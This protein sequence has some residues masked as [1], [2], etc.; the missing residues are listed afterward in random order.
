MYELTA[1]IDDAR[2]A[3]P[4][5][6]RL[7]IT[8]ALHGRSKDGMHT[9]KRNAQDEPFLRRLYSDLKSMLQYCKNMIHIKICQIL[10]PISPYYCRL[11]RGD[12]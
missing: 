2:P 8:R 11:A 3:T 10:Y 7:R 12:N 4:D 9:Q 5:Q 6:K 1:I